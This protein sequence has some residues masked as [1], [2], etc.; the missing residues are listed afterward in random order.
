MGEGFM[1]SLTGESYVLD[2]CYICCTVN[3]VTA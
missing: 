3:L 1:P 2:I